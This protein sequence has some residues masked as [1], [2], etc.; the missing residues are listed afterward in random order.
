MFCFFFLCL[1]GFVFV[2]EAEFRRGGPVEGRSLQWGCHVL[3][4]EKRSAD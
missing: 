1:V 3:E 4:K 2:E